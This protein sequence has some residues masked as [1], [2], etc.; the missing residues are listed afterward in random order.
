MYPNLAMPL[1]QPSGLSSG[2]LIRDLAQSA[3]KMIMLN[4]YQAEEC[5]HMRRAPQD[6]LEGTGTQPDFL[7]D[8]V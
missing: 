1:T 4:G 8:R 7:S 2:K 3:G 5:E 6:T